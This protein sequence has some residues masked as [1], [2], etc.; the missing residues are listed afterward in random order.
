MSKN[1]KHLFMILDPPTLVCWSRANVSQGLNLISSEF[2]DSRRFGSDFRAAN[3]PKNRAVFRWNNAYKLSP[4]RQLLGKNRGS[5]PS[6]FQWSL[7]NETGVLLSYF[8]SHLWRSSMPH[9]RFQWRFYSIQNWT[10]PFSPQRQNIDSTHLEP[11]NR[12]SLLGRCTCHNRC[13]PPLS[14]R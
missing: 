11:N 3:R 8:P 2:E 5:M 7:V 14:L 12:L 6:I 9:C 10:V 13:T 4:K 1:C